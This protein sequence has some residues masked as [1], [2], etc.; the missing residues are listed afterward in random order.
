MDKKLIFNASVWTFA[1]YGT[2]QV[3]KLVSNLIMTRL[4][5]P[6]DF[7][8]MA[9]GIAIFTGITLFSDIG[10][11]PSIIQNKRAV[12]SVF[13]NTAWTVQII[14][15]FVIWFVSCG[16]AFF[17][18]LLNTGEQLVSSASVYGH[19]QL[20]LLICIIGFTGVISGFQ[21]TSFFTN[22]RSLYLGRITAI[23][24]VAQIIS[25]FSMV[26]WALI[27]ASIWALVFGMLIG[28]SLKTIFT[29]LYLPGVRNKLVIER[30]AFFELFHF[31]KWI[32]LAT[33]ANYIANQGAIFIFGYYLTVSEMGVYS[34]ALLL[35]AVPVTVISK[36]SHSILFPLY[37][38]LYRGAPERLQLTVAKTRKVLLLIGMPSISFLM[39][40]GEEI[41]SFL[42]DDRYFGAG[43][44][45]QILLFIA[46]INAQ[47]TP[48][49]ILLLARGEPKYATLMSV[50]KGIIIFSMIPVAFGLYGVQGMLYVVSGSSILSAIIIWIV[51]TKKKLL[52][53]KIEILGVA[54]FFLSM[55]LWA[56]IYKQ[57]YY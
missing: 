17:L 23:E 16:I 28:I 34:I 35:S 49:Y 26:V 31:G 32:L 40:F 44:M 22:S 15:G 18:W 12:D 6:D 21:S 43:E 55:I 37:S 36:Y 2:S 39:V 8:L 54:T 11:G 4:L 46:V 50:M 13:L 45:M 30:S 51:L 42:Y 3:L 52:N 57:I 24:I 53:I 41:V 14:R 1:G 29:H 5:I 20:P 9:I 33:I 27:D 48:S 38:H 19:H 47:V 7:G 25:I 10:I 56:L